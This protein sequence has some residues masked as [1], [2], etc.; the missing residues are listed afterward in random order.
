MFLIGRRNIKYRIHKIKNKLEI[1]NINKNN[2]YNND[3]KII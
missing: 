1:N 2:N 3:N